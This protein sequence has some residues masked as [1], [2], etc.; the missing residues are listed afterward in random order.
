MGTSAL[1]K[2][3][4]TL[5]LTLSKTK[6]LQILDVNPAEPLMLVRAS[7]GLGGRGMTGMM[8]ELKISKCL[9]FSASQEANDPQT[10]A[11]TVVTGNIFLL[12]IF[13]DLI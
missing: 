1:N 2:F 11:N 6:A 5:I 4:P 8:R 9:A 3:A 10:F 13:I 12:E 7:L